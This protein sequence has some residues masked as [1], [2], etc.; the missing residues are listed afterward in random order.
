MAKKHVKKVLTFLF[1]SEMQ[2]KIILRVHL[3]SVRN[4][5][6]KNSSDSSC[7][8]GHGAGGNILPPLMGRKLAQPL[9]KSIWSFNSN[10]RIV[11]PQDPGISLLGIYPKDVPL[12]HRDTCITMFT[13]VL[14]A[15]SRICSI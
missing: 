3:T 5:K 8:G 9:W 2:I 12:Y 14:F 7:L 13:A 6:T 15:V 1:M 11:V 4:A 10:V